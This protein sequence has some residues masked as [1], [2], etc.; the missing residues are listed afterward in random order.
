MPKSAGDH[1]EPLLAV[2]QIQV[3]PR[4][5]H[6]AS[7]WLLKVVGSHW[8]HLRWKEHA[9]RTALPQSVDVGPK[10]VALLV[11]LHAALARLGV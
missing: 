7:C 6:L 5:F 1:F 10:E 9:S 4:P 11:W 8:Q 3:V 2:E